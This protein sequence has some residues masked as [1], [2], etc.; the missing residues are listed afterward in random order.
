MNIHTDFLIFILYS[1]YLPK[2]IFIQHIHAYSYKGS[3]DAKLI[4]AVK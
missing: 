3:R 1:T 4:T 2:H